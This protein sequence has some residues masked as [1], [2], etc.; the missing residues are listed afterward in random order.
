MSTA[1]T[2]ICTRAR[3]TE[4][5]FDV[6]VNGVIVAAASNYHAAELVAREV[7]AR[8]AQT[9]I[10]EGLELHAPLARCQQPDDLCSVDDPC[11]AHAA[12]ARAYLDAEAEALIDS[13]MADE[14]AALNDPRC[15]CGSPAMFFVQYPHRV[16]A[17]CPECYSEQKS[18][19]LLYQCAAIIRRCLGSTT[20]AGGI[21]EELRRVEQ[22]LSREG[23]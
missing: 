23:W 15:P 13:A 7:E 5:I 14:L 20:G 4:H 12:D 3:S 17:Y 1:I 16:Y 21:I 18:P 10:V 6:E 8:E 11:P 22:A 9:I 2:Y 19:P